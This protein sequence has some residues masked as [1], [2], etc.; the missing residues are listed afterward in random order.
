MAG[1]LRR[2]SAVVGAPAD[3]AAAGA[4]VA[5]RDVPQLAGP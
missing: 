3:A 1:S 5:A 4:L 2:K